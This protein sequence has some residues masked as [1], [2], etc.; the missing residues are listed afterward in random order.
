MTTTASHTT[1]RRVPRI[2]ASLSA[3]FALMFGFAVAPAHAADGDPVIVQPLTGAE[4][5]SPFFLEF[6]VPFVPDPNSLQIT[7]DGIAADVILQPTNQQS[8]QHSYTISPENPNSQS[9]F[10]SITPMDG[11]I[12]ED[13]YTI[14]ISYTSGGATYSSSVEAVRIGVG[15]VGTT[16]SDQTAGTTAPTTTAPSSSCPITLKGKVGFKCMLNAAK[17]QSLHGIPIRVTVAKK[18]SK[19]C[20]VANGSIRGKKVGTCR[21]VITPIVTNYLGKKHH[22]SLPVV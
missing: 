5:G 11:R 9:E 19:I 3:A 10:M 16:V 15:A 17:L 14:R 20:S 1:S 7:F 6:S 2:I 13:L 21:L 18:S 4:L 22:V 12:T 8:G